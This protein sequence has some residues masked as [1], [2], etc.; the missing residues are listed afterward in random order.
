M[1]LKHKNEVH[2]IGNLGKDPNIRHSGSW[3]MATLNV[4]TT[5]RWQKDGEWKEKTS[6]H[7]VVAWNKVAE[8]AE[9]G[10]SKGDLVEIKGS[11][12]TRSYDDK[13][14]VKKWVTQINA[15]SI[16]KLEKDDTV[17]TPTAAPSDEDGDELPF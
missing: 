6:W 13:N 2:L 14:G 12:E 3:T 4:A 5:N 1:A 11:L 16:A 8:V 10:L 9:N 17:S 7:N 15:F